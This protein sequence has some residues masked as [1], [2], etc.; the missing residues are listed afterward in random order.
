MCERVYNLNFGC[1]A[2]YSSILSSNSWRKCF[3]RP[4]TGHA[5]AS[6]NAHIVCPSICFVSSC[7]MSIYA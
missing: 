1:F 4:C 3:I 7:N 6:P 5:A 2:W